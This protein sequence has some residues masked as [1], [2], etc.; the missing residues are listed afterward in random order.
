MKEISLQTKQRKDKML[1]LLYLLPMVVVFVVFI[2]IPV[3]SVFN[4][5]FYTIRLNGSKVW[6]GL[7]NYKKFIGDTKT[8]LAFKNTL[9]WVGAGT[10]AKILLGLLM[11]LILYKEFHGKRLLTGVMLIPYATPAAVSCMIWRNMYHPSFGHIGQFLRDIGILS[12]EISFLGNMK[13]SL[14][15]V[16]IVNVWAV[17]P[18]CALNILATLYSIPTYLYEAADI[19][20]ANAIERFFAITFPLILRDVRTLALLI[21][22]WAFNSFDV[23]YMMTT[24]GPANSSSIF[25]NLIYQNAFEFNNRGYSAA[26]S[27]VCFILLSIL[28][29][30]YVRSKRKDISYE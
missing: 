25:V 19:D 30:F 14:I 8:L 15:A 9:I 10:L 6:L 23:I 29:V 13:T 18:F 3:V 20:G 24:G 5:S 16:M 28:A 26:I 4:N 12:G 22:I 7:N 17:A 1:N 21:A 11:A 27:V 2:I